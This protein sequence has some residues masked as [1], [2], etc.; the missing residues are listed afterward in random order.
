MYNV[1]CIIPWKYEMFQ[2]YFALDY[3]K[4]LFYEN[5]FE[6]SYIQHI[7]SKAVEF[8]DYIDC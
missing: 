2:F 5:D 1:Y 8:I 7:V 4:L 6:T 3:K